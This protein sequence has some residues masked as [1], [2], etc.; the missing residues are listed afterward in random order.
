MTLQ[1]LTA[2]DCDI[3]AI[4]A[5]AKKLIDTYEDVQS[6][7]YDKVL[8]WVERKITQNISQYKVVVSNG[9]KC[10]F[11][12]LCEDGELDDLYVLPEFQNAGIGSDILHKCI[13]EAKAPLYLYVFARNNRAIAFYERFGFFIRETVGNTRLIMAL[14]VDTRKIGDYNSKRLN[15]K[16]IEL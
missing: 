1:Y 11:Y 6:I 14:K 10:A 5:Q 13:R 4:Y 2:E 9:E 8:A 15:F 16:E 7:D 3:P 12:R